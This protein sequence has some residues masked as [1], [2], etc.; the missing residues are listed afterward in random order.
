LENIADPEQD[1]SEIA[2]DNENK[3]YLKQAV[4]SLD[5]KY[6]IPLLLKYFYNQSN[7]SIAET[8]NLK[9]TTVNQRISRGKRQAGIIFRRLKYK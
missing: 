9:I 3:R 8:L 5:G 7:T 4:Q 6:R 2:I 1:L